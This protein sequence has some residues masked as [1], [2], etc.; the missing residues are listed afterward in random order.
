M[1]R[2]FFEY[3]QKGL[4][5]RE[6]FLSIFGLFFQYFLSIF[7]LL[8]KRLF[9]GRIFFG[10]FLSP[11]KNTLPGKWFAIVFSRPLPSLPS[12]RS[13]FFLRIDIHATSLVV[14]SLF[15]LFGARLAASILRPLVRT[16][17]RGIA[18]TPSLCSLVCSA[19]L[20]STHYGLEEVTLQF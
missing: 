17:V 15:H 9:Q 13:P 10:Y 3:F 8:R 2:V 11:P 20:L 7:C 16:P 12:S 5:S 14:S 18:S 19:L 1:S 4:V 6:Y